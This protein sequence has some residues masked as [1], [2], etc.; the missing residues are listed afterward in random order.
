MR[1]PIVCVVKAPQT[2]KTAATRTLAQVDTD[3]KSLEAGSTRKFA[4]IDAALKRLE[5]DGASKRWVLWRSSTYLD[6]VQLSLPYFAL[7]GFATKEQCDE[8]LR[9]RIADGMQPRS[10]V[11][12]TSYQAIDQRSGRVVYE[13]YCLPDS[14]DP[15]HAPPVAAR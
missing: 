12:K 1:N 13:F 6:L 4:E 8:G 2:D 11:T 5:Q 14:V 10:S 3:L 7:D 15:R 9:A